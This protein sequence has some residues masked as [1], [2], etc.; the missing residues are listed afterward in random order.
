MVIELQRLYQDGWTDGLIFIK[1]IL[2]CRSIELR[3]ANNERNVS[4]VPEG[5]YPMAIIQHPKFGECLLVNN[6]KGRSG[7]LVHVA[8][9]AQKELRG[10]IAPVFSLS[11][12]GK[13]LH[14]RLALNYIIEN[15]KISGEKDHFIEIKSKK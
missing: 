11:G 15:L 14:S 2:L 7:I 6:V 1:G 5:V 4:C 9:D 10:C 8:N 12:N 13:G 3:W